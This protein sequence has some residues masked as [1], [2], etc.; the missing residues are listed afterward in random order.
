MVVAHR[1]TTVLAEQNRLVV[2]DL[3][4]ARLG[5]ALKFDSGI[6]KGGFRLCIN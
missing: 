2:T 1:L 5:G 3:V 6:E 4:C